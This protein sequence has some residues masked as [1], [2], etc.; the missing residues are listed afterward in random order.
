MVKK[1]NSLITIS[2]NY[3][4]E[5]GT[6][7]EESR[8]WQGSMTDRYNFKALDEEDFTMSGRKDYLNSDHDKVDTM[9]VLNHEADIRP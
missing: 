2:G 9:W 4:P 6:Y 5:P 7:D 8:S 3:A 1:Y